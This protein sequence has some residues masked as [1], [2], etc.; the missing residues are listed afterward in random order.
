MS[1]KLL[2]LFSES[3]WPTGYGGAYIEPTRFLTDV[4]PVEAHTQECMGAW[5]RQLVHGHAIG[6][7]A[8]SAAGLLD[9]RSWF[10]GFG[11]W[12]HRGD[13]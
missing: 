5:L 12:H 4:K 2:E 9:G 7:G 1:G 10:V 13:R 8:S 6:A 3:A 11:C